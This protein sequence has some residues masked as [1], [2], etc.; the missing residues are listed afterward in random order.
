MAGA[1]YTREGTGTQEHRSTG[2]QGEHD[3]HR[4]RQTVDLGKLLGEFRQREELGSL[5]RAGLETLPGVLEIVGHLNLVLLVEGHFAAEEMTVG[6][7]RTGFPP[8]RE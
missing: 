3:A 2:V 1:H 4:H 6:A 7:G 8:S 5:A